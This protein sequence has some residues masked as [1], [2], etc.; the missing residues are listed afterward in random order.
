MVIVDEVDHAPR[1]V[2]V[3]DPWGTDGPGS[4]SG[5]EGVIELAVFLELWRRGIHNAVWR[6]G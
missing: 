3:R 4:G 1:E 5:V 2:L 6:Q